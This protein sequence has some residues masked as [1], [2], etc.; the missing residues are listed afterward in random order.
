MPTPAAQL[1]ASSR[2]NPANDP[3]SKEPMKRK[4]ILVVDD[5][6]SFTRLLKMNLEE[7][8]D[9]E[10]RLETWA[11]RALGAAR[12]F[13]PDLIL[14]DLVM[15]Q[16]RGDQLAARFRADAKVGATPVVFL[17]A[18]VEKRQV[19][20]AHGLING[21]PFIAKPASV[22]EIVE[23]I[24]RHLGGPPGARAVPAAVCAAA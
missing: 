4:K 15:P 18:A 11:E 14:L 16:M 8:D 13:E 10:V 5:E 9:Y 3:P 12:E 19:Q 22:D 23:G 21:H 2:L 1:A 7:T 6:L 24:E 17:S 20:E